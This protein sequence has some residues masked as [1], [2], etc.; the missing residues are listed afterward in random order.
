LLVVLRRITHVRKIAKIK[1]LG[2]R[3]RGNCFLLGRVEY[4]VADYGHYRDAR[5]NGTEFSVRGMW[6]ILKRCMRAAPKEKDGLL[7]SS[8]VNH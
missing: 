7:S 8:I 2:G 4:L 1:V 5:E 6:H 3:R